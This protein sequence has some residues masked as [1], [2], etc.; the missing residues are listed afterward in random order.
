MEMPP[1]PDPRD[2]DCAESFHWV[3]FNNAL[4]AWERVA[5]HLIDKAHS[6]PTPPATQET[7]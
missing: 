5:K 1:M 4:A 3:S 2:F 7:T 6:E